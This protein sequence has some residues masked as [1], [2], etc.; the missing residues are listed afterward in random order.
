MPNGFLSFTPDQIKGLAAILSAGSPP[1]T[2]GAP[3]DG[4]ALGF[5]APGVV[6]GAPGRIAFTGTDAMLLASATP[7]DFYSVTLTSL[8]G[9]M[10]G[11][12]GLTG[13]YGATSGA[14]LSF[15]GS[16]SLVNTLLANITDTV[17]V[18]GDIVQVVATDSAGNTAA[19]TVGVQAAA[20]AVPPAVTLGL[21]TADQL[22]DF[23]GGVARVVGQGQAG[24][25]TLADQLGSNGMLIVAGVQSQL[26]VAGNLAL[27]DDTSLLAALS[28]NASAPRASRSAARSRLRPPPRPISPAPSRPTRS[29]T[30]ARSGATA[31][32]TPRAATPSPTPG[33][34][35]RWP[36]TR[37]ARSGWSFRTTSQGPA[38]SPS[39]PAPR[40][41]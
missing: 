24:S 35:R 17:A 18:G 21:L 28:P 33:P 26:T 20:P 36:I 39:M 1:P 4:S 13:L 27:T 11:I 29:P 12:G 30:A 32:S 23:S 2:A 19:R 6:T 10:L 38:S 37:W 16:L 25:L 5:I 15:S 40:W 34:S 8:G 9:G 3:D 41:S 22:F 31:R 14:T 7:Q